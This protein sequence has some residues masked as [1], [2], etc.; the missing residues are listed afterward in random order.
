MLE[1]ADAII[2]T[3]GQS[4]GD[5][6]YGE[7]AAAMDATGLETTT[8]SAHFQYRRGGERRK[9]VKISTIVLCGSLLPVG[10]VL[11]WG[12][13][14]DKCQ[15]QA[16]IEKASQATWPAKLYADAGYDAEWI[17]DQ[18]R[19]QWGVESVIKPAVHR[20]DGK[21][22][23]V[24]RS[25]MSEKYLKRQKYGRRWAV[26]TFFSGLKRTMGS[27]LTSRKPNQLLAEAAF[28]V[29]AYTLRR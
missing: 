26:E 24:W 22:G 6:A 9:W 13:N 1:I 14:N 5:A 19:L 21:R 28:R 3:I 7:G 17:H 4:A 16:L 2:K 10:L 27:M 15:A 8:A 25:E 11:D 12:P 23:G 29:L 18:C 20:S